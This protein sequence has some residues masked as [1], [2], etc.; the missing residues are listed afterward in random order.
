MDGLLHGR[1]ED[2]VRTDFRVRAGKKI[3]CVH[4]QGWWAD[5]EILCGQTVA[6]QM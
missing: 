3:M 6:R 1:C 5:V 2:F 4:I